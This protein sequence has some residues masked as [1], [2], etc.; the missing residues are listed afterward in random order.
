MFKFA[1]TKLSINEVWSQTFSLYKQTFKK[2]WLVALISIVAINI[3]SLFDKTLHVSKNPEAPG[4]LQH[5]A[6]MPVAMASHLLM[7]SLFIVAILVAIYFSATVMHRI[8]NYIS[9]EKS[10]LGDSF[11]HVGSKYLILLVSLIALYF[12]ILCG[13]LILVLL[14][15]K[16]WGAFGL[17]PWVI[18]A[19]FILISCMFN[20]PLI[21]FDHV[22]SIAALKASY[23]L[24][25]GNWWNTFATIMT[26]TII[27]IL[28]QLLAGMILMPLKLTIITMLVQAIIG[29][30][31]M[32]FIQALILVQFNNL[33]KHKTQ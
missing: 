2:V 12:T 21:L 7:L 30:I 20:I 5:A 13:L 25:R 29:V 3:P 31:T 14:P 33:K 27:I 4:T 23:K 24:V 11:R 10:E 22:G 6:T 1:K 16:L 32:P 17:L 26:P 8:Y 18:F 9:N 19:I 15:F 28:A